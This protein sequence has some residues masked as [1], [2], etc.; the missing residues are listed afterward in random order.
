MSEE[1]S[2]ENKQSENIE[3]PPEKGSDEEVNPSP[4]DLNKGDVDTAA[5]GEDIADPPETPLDEDDFSEEN[6]DDIFDS[7]EEESTEK[8]T[9]TSSASETSNIEDG[10]DEENEENPEQDGPLFS[11]DNKNDKESREIELGIETDDSESPPSEETDDKLKESETE[12]KSFDE[13]D[14]DDIF[15]SDNQSE[16]E[17]KAEEE[18]EKKLP[19]ADDESPLLKDIDEILSDDNDNDPLLDSNEDDLAASETESGTDIIDDIVDQAGIE[20]DALWEDDGES[21]EI[22]LF[23]DV[24]IQEEL[25]AEEENNLTAAEEKSQ[26]HVDL[27]ESDDLQKELSEEPEEDDTSQT[28]E[29]DDEPGEETA[30]WWLPWAVTAVA[31]IFTFTGAVVLWQMA[32]DITP[33]QPAFNIPVKKSGKVETSPLKKPLAETE[34]VD[35]N[36]LKK[37]SQFISMDL[38]P[39]LI[40]AH[41]EGELVFLKLKVELIL[42]DHKTLTDIRK[43]KAWV[44]DAIYMELKGIEL[45][46]G[47]KGDILMQYRRPVLERLNK[48]IAPLEVQDLRLTGV[49][50]K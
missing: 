48:E 29:E 4:E 22:S 3:G 33:P 12:D 30:S 20:E 1:K 50:L 49:M 13:L 2:T 21:N 15:S 34:I 23:E 28:A 11:D 7:P 6:L 24:L 18:K 37:G 19:D 46:P 10:T 42:P 5:N 16:E 31:L 45:K 44:R 25:A 43:R 32:H 17:S 9:V 39:F 27:V 38:A 41:K 40:P 35:D 36:P 26:D 8:T 47:M 14:I